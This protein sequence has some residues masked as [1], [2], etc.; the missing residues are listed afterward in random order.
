M[1]VIAAS[2]MQSLQD[3]LSWHPNLEFKASKLGKTWFL[4]VANN[5]SGEVKYLSE[6][7]TFGEAVQQLSIWCHTGM[8]I[9]ELPYQEKLTDEHTE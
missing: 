9:A 1:D 2:H 6:A 3:Y 4:S 7:A 5:R 8:E